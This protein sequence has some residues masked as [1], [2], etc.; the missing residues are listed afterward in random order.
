MENNLSLALSNS[1]ST[2]ASSIAT[3][4][5]EIGLDSI[6]EEGLLKEVPIL[7]TVVSLFKIGQSIKDRHQIKKL[8]NFIVALNNGIIDEEK[9]EYYKNVVKDDPQKRKKELEYILIS[10]DRYI[11]SNKAQLLA[12]FYL[13][14]LDQKIDWNFF[15]KAS[16]IL[17]R[18]LPGDYDTL[19]ER[20]WTAID[21]IQV[22]DS[23]IRL[24][25]LGLVI[26]HNNSSNYNY[27][28]DSSISIPISKRKDYEL[29]E[30]GENFLECLS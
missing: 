26:V 23:L 21:D 4:L 13:A 10:I 16:E 30:L 12:K 7:S 15:A 1:I 11:N 5:L 14:Y 27:V 25:S 3:N 2:E 19:Q 18:F 20:S 29:T 17:D 28:I 6:M 8:L 9:R 24:M 22:S